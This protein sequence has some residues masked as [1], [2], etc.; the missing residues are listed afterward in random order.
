[1][2]R[3]LATEAKIILERAG[4]VAVI[5][6]VY[7]NIY[8]NQQYVNDLVISSGTVHNPMVVALLAARGF[9]ETGYPQRK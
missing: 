7:M 4:Y 3:R 9:D 6:K 1:M 5:G 2:S 8:L